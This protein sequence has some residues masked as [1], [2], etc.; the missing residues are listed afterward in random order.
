MKLGRVQEA[1]VWQNFVRGREPTLDVNDARGRVIGGGHQELVVFGPAHFVDEAQVALHFHVQAAA[2]YSE[3]VDGRRAALVHAG[4]RQKAA[5]RRELD[6][7][8]AVLG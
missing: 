4:T 1:G 7:I 2:R 3:D 6:R 8:A 5:A